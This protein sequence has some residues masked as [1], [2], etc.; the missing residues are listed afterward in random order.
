MTTTII[1]KPIDDSV[2]DK[3]MSFLLGIVV[4]IVFSLLFYIYII[5]SMRKGWERFTTSE[6]NVTLPK[7]ANVNKQQSN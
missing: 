2:V 3:G 6:T 7:T 4:F 1:N 5:P